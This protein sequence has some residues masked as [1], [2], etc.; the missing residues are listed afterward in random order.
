MA[1]MVWERGRREIKNRAGSGAVAGSGWLVGF[2][3]LPFFTQTRGACVT[4]QSVMRRRMM[5]LGMVRTVKYGGTERKR[6]PAVTVPG[7]DCCGS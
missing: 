1:F 6:A 3:Q 2:R 4:R 7:V 5:K